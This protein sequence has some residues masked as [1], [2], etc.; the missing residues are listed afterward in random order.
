MTRHL[1]IFFS[2]PPHHPQVLHPLCIHSLIPFTQIFVQYSAK[3]GVP[4]VTHCPHFS[5]RTSQISQNLQPRSLFPIHPF[6]TW[7]TN[8]FHSLKQKGPFWNTSD[9]LLF[10]QSE[11]KHFRR[12]ACTRNNGENSKVL[13][14][15]IYSVAQ[16]ISKLDGKFIY[17]L[18][19][20]FNRT[21][22]RSVNM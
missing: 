12:I 6:G 17:R 18:K 4:L 20:A 10:P 8:W 3:E 21:T 15:S 7:L 14:K 9:N 19:M 5:A 11:L 13:E 1:S 22:G 16:L 2:L